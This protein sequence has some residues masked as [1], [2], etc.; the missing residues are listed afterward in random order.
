MGQTIACAN[1]KGGVGKTTT[2]VNLGDA[3]SASRASASSS[4]ISIPRAT[5]RA[6]SGIDRGAIERSSTTP[7]STS[8]Q[9]ER[10]DR[11]RTASTGCSI[12]PSVDRAG[13]RGGRAGA[14]SSSASA[15]CAA[16][17]RDVAAD[18]DY[19]LIDCP[20]SLG[21][22]TVNALT[23]ADSVLIPLQCEY[24][25]LEG[26]DPAARHARP[27][28]RPPEPGAR[29]Q[30]RRPDDVRR[31]GRT[32]RPTSPPRSAA[33]S[34]TASS[35]R[36][37]RAA[38]ASPRR[39]ATAC[40]S[41]S[42]A[43]TRRGAIAYAALAAELRARDG[44]APS[45]R[46]ARPVA[47]PVEAPIAPRRAM[48]A[49]M[50]V[51]PER[52]TGLG[53]GLASLIPQRAPGSRR[54]IEIPIDRIRPNPRQPRQRIDPDELATPRREHPRARRPPADPRDRDDRRLPA[55]RRRAPPPGGQAGRPR[56][57]PGRRP[58]AR[59]PRRSS[60]SRSSRTS[61]ARTST[62]SR[63]RTR[64]RQLDRR[65]RLH[66]GGRRRRASGGPAP[67]SRTRS[68]CSTSTPARP[69]RGRRR[70]THRGP[71]PRPRRPAD[72]APGPRARHGR[73]AGALG[74][75]DRGA[76]PPAARAAPGA[77]RRAAPRT[78]RSRTSSGSRRTCAA[79]SARRSAW[80][81]RG[82]AAGSSSSTTATRSSGGSTS[83]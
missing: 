17:L 55:R 29:D 35:R 37:S 31:A 26:L 42:I 69:G 6:A 28:P 62:R 12:V 43:R 49:V 1:Q 16:L 23:A 56:A 4:S 44:R 48:V 77:G 70:P 51:R 79:R 66:P 39:R 73:R 38:S 65:V 15:G 32:C 82:G 68:A 2:V 10:S 3:I 36:S 53:R 34:A 45:R 76:R 11:R 63:T 14:A 52:R 7:S 30:G 33:I 20:P 47:P 83:A 64:Y 75:P 27:R 61:S 22:L 24:Y 60:S 5:R 50:T 71:R 72:G 19:V 25:A 41:R 78:G 80:P 46:R 58:P 74:S 81:G 59:R 13:R 18:Y 54:P 57:D 40:R 21:L 67:P 9:L 8:V